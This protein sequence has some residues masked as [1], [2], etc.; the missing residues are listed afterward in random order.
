MS[1]QVWLPLTKDTNVISEIATLSKESAVTITEDTNGWYKIADSSHTSG[2]WGAY[3]SFSVKPNTRYTLQVYSKSTTG[4]SA[5]IGI[6]SYIGTSSW[7]AVRDTNNSSTEKL[8]TYTWK[9]GVNDT[10]A[11]VYLAIA[12]GSTT[13]NNYVFYKGLKVYEEPK[14]EG[15]SE[16]DITNKGTTYQSAGG[17]LGGCYYFAGG[18]SV[19]NT[20]FSIGNKFSIALWVKFNTIATSTNSYLVSLNTQTSSDEQFIV[21]VYRGSSGT[22][23]WRF[24]LT[25]D[26]GTVEANKWYHVCM[27]YTG[28]QANI[29]IDGQLIKTFNHNLPSTTAKHLVIN[30]RANSADGYSS[31]AGGGSSFYINDVRIYD[32]CLS[33][34]EIKRIS[35]GL[36]LHYPLN[37][38]Y[39]E[40]TTNL[41]T[42]EDCLSSTCYNGSTS[43]YGYGTTTDIYKTVTTY[44]GRKGT[45]VYMGTN[46]NNCYP[47]VYISNMYTSNGT[48]APAYKTLSFDYYTTISTSISPYKLGSGNGTAT[49]IVS[50]KNGIETGT[51]TNSVVIPVEPNTWNHIEVTFHGTTDADAQWGYIQNRPAHTSNTSNFWFFANMQLET[52]D[53]ATGYVGF[54]KTRNNS[55]I[56]DTSG[57][58]NNGNVSGILTTSNDTLQY[59]ISSYFNGSS[60][61]Q[62]INNTYLSGDLDFTIAFWIKADTFTNDYASVIWNGYSGVNQAIAICVPNGKVS[63]DFWNNRYLT[64]NVVLTTNKWHHVCCTKIAGAVSTSNSHIYIDG[65]E[66]LATA[67]NYS[68]TAPNISGNY[69]WIIGRLNDTSTRYITGKV[70]DIRVYTTSLSDLDVLELYNMGHAATT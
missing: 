23:V 7:P 21:G 65:Q 44:D 69:K 53:H 67:N 61:I 5:S 28:T 6:Q 20:N 42:T 52:K 24:N 51:G 63:L 18:T 13:S 39:V 35:Q 10:T 37:D 58:N 34:Q 54:N 64:N 26:C 47:Y 56:Y 22:G 1:L 50:N 46:G 3:Y 36:V 70:S 57:F 12:C 4:V 9:T 45:K 2:R 40:T 41:I 48:N 68:T 11:R 17:K 8:T 66:V 25:G 31:I 49:Y 38:S 30:G 59:K 19:Y 14:N 33:S 15:F 60:Y 55:I 32:H 62:S 16:I 27:T 29:Y 43:K